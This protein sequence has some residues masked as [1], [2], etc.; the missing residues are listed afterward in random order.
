MGIEVPHCFAWRDHLN[1]DYSFFGTLSME[2]KGQKQKRN[3][4]MGWIAES[5]LKLVK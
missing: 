1:Y 2:T 5:Y 3:D 4:N